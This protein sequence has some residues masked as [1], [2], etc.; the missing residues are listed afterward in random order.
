VKCRAATIP[1]VLIDFDA[2][3]SERAFDRAVLQDLRR[4]LPDTT[5]IWLALATRAVVAA[6]T[7]L[8]HAF[9]EVTVPAA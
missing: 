5:R 2:K 6:A 8:H 3:T 1:A 9:D 7:G 4:T